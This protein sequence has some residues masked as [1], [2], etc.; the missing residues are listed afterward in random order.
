MLSVAFVGGVHLHTWVANLVLI[1]KANGK[2]RICV[3]FKDLKKSCPKN[4]YSLPRIYQLLDVTFKH[5]T[6]SLTNTY[7]R[8]NQIQMYPS[9][10]V[11]TI[12]Y[13]DKDILCYQVI[14][15]GFIYA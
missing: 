12:V 14:P 2:W 5:E 7:S 6:L 8:Y 11:H 9:D 10:E 3:D 4:S 13:A 1:I 15:F